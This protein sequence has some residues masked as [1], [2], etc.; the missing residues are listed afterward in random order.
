MPGVL[1]TTVTA[2]AAALLAG[3]TVGLPAPVFRS[4]VRARDDTLANRYDA[5]YRDRLGSR[6]REV[7]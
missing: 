1:R 7:A 3:A 4:D 6:V 5:I 2:D